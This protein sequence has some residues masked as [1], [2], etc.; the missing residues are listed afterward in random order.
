MRYEQ[1][2]LMPQPGAFP[3]EKALSAVVLGKL[4][5]WFHIEEQVPGRYWTGEE[6]RIDAVLR[7]RDP[8]GWHDDAPAFG[9]EFKNPTL[10]TSTGDRYGWVTQAVGYAHC[11]WQGYGRLGIFLCPS[12]LSWLLS[13]ADEIASARQK[14]IGPEALETERAR[15]RDYGRLF[16]KEYSDA[17]V[18][19]EALLAHR[20]TLGELTYQEFTARADGFV[21]ADERQQEHDLRM[22]DELTHLI[23]QLGVGELMPYERIGWALMRS[24]MRLWS[25]QDG[26]TRI[27]F[28]LRP[29]IGSR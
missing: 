22:A 21:N 4:D 16:G 24:G 25:E 8:K 26:V 20:R 7:P 12:P 9:V 17:Y 15:V 29:R 18:D 13:R 6:T 11:D 10:N 3:D 28:R 19:S 1:R 27:P 5:R 2:P 23:G 14:R